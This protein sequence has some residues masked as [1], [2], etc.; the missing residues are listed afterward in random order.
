MPSDSEIVAATDAHDAGRDAA[1]MLEGLV[2]GCERSDL[3]FRS[4][5]P[6]HEGDDWNDVFEMAEP[7]GTPTRPCSG[8]PHRLS[9]D[10]EPCALGNPIRPGSR[11]LG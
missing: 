6:L 9:F 2:R 7:E 4:D 1:E 11:L 5:L 3:S 10:A 8:A